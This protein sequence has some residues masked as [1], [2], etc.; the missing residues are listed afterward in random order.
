MKRKRTIFGVGTL[1]LIFT[2]CIPL[3]LLGKNPLLNNVRRYV[4]D[5]PKE[6]PKQNEWTFTADRVVGDYTSEYV[7]AFGNCTLALGKDQLRAD[8]ARYY[9]NT[10]WVFLKG[11]IRAQWGGD[12]LQAD[13]GEF[14]LNNMTG[15]L[16]NGKLFMAKPHI[17]VEAER[18][19]KAKGDSYTFKNAKVT[20]CEGET[21]AWSV[22]SEEGDIQLDG[23]V[24]LYR[25]AFR[26]K[27][28]PVFY[29]P[30]MSLPGRQKRESG[31]LM[32]SISNSKKLGFQMN[33]PYYWVISEEAD[34]T[35]YQNFMSS[36]G[37]QQGIEFRHANDSSTK[38]LW[39]VDV[40][41]DKRRAKTE[42]QE[43]ED[44]NS[45]GLVRPNSSRWWVRSKYDGWLGSP[46]LQV[47]LDLDLVSDQNY[48]R[49]FENGPNGFDQ[50]RENFLDTFGRGIDNIDSTTR[51]STALLSRSWDRFGLTG[52]IE[53]IQN[54]EYMNGNGDDEDNTTVQTLPELEAFAFQQ[55][56]AGT[57]FEVAAETKYDYFARNKGHTGHRFRATPE[58]KMPLSTDYV[59]FTPFV[60]GDY[61]YYNVD[62]DGYGN[63]T[64]VD[65]G[66]RTQ[67]ID[68]NAT[69]NG[70]QSRF[71]YTTGFDA[72]SEMTRVYSLSD[73]VKA[74]PSLAGT[75]RWTRLK[76]SIVP[77]VAY[78]YT[79]TIT[80]QDKYAYFDEFDRIQAKDEVTYSITNVLDR[81]R[82]T[83]KLSPGKEGSPKAAVVSDYLDFLIFR[84]EQSY[85]RNEANRK[86]SLGEYERRP[87]SDVM[88]EL[89]VRPEDYIDLISR[90]WFSP[91]KAG[92]T[93]SESTIR[94]FKEGLGE[95]SIGYDYLVKIDEY[96]RY[97]DSTMSI[98]ELG[99]KWNV[100]E[101][102]LL[103]AKWRHDFNKERDLERAL[104]LEWSSGCYVLNLGFIMKP[105][106][107]RFEFGFNLMNF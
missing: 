101:D 81:R 68:T 99:G 4:P 27:D 32:P 64:Y 5:T 25:S 75:S 8:F 15:W 96:K 98:I 69:K 103:S 77:R 105:N 42:A 55:K 67:N 24:Q 62:Y 106:D 57:P 70:S 35:L 97:R 26:I 1:V 49:D 54:L 94:V 61:T 16:K 14:D 48:L 59:T 85:D 71:A 60:S 66:G 45:D 31:F 9:Q 7:E 3:T 65:S 91:Y 87:F 18:V 84:L 76:H 28:V 44:Y 29:W 40:M 20:A 12:F 10:G 34:M 56:L 23:K 104:R 19:G 53:Y 83:V 86:D 47:K 93:K 90:T 79:P 11:N 102:F 92:L 50:T 30:Y 82:E 52:K 22:T 36:R 95:F 2:L 38:G 13:E 73:E 41:K 63:Q 39:M 107:Q 17:Y 51:T 100:S 74:E 89:T 78:K 43:W 80:G 58:L 88:A 33:L 46:Q 6:T 72:F 37:Y 21:P